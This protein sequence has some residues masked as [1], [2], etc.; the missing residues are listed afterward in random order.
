[1]MS[2]ILNKEKKNSEYIGLQDIDIGLSLK[3]MITKR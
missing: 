1:M 2:T 3:P